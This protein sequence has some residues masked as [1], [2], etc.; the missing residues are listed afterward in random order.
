[1]TT[2]LAEISNLVYIDFVKRLKIMTAMSLMALTLQN[3]TLL[4]SSLL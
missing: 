1:M 3:Y 2:Y 4:T